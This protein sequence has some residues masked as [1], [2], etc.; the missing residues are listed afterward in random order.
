[1]LKGLSILPTKKYGFRFA[2]SPTDVLMAIIVY[3]YQA[4]HNNYE[5]SYLKGI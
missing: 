4:L 1:M 3:E 2:L 5:S